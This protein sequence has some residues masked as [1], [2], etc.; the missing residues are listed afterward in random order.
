MLVQASFKL[1]VYFLNKNV[2]EKIINRSLFMSVHVYV[3]FHVH[4]CVHVYGDQTLMSV[5][6][7]QLSTTYCLT[8]GL[9]LNLKFTS[10]ATVAGPMNSKNPPVPTS[11]ALGS[12]CMPGFIA[13]C[14]FFKYGF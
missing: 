10:L 8:Q 4:M 2:T 14:L 3:W 7:P 6:V 1:F 5:C 12:K 13:V 9:S 11:T